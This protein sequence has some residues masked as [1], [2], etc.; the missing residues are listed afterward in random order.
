[1]TL[2]TP[3]TEIPTPKPSQLRDSPLRLALQ[4]ARTHAMIARAYLG[5]V[6]RYDE[7]V[8]A[9]DVRLLEKATEMLLHAQRMLDSGDPGTE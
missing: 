4:D 8:T 3:N 1:M 5:N 9:D 7:Q 6:L 2:T